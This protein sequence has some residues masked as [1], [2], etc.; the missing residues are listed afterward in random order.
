MEP[1][2]ASVMLDLFWLVFYGSAPVLVIAAAVGLVVAVLQGVMQINDQT[3]PQVLKT[4]ATM[5]VLIAFAA[6]SFGPLPRVMI[7][8]L[9]MIP[10]IGR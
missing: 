5:V 4:A 2:P 3:L 6:L 10:A 8:Y 9:E 7:G 1:S